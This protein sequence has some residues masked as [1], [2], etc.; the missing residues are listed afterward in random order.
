[1]T[2]KQSLIF[3][4]S[5]VA[6]TFSLIGWLNVSLL[7]PNKYIWVISTPIIIFIAIVEVCVTTEAIERN[8]DDKNK[9]N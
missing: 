9:S 4:C 1:M 8:R 5:F 6:I 7:S 2:N 3:L